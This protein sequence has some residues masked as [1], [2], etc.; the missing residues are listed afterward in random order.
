MVLEASRRLTRAHSGGLCHM[1]GSALLQHLKG[2]H[3]SGTPCPRLPAH[4]YP[5][6]AGGRAEVGTRGLQA[7]SAQAACA[8]GEC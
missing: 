5:H 2:R 8:G 6:Q 1:S 4:N 3:S 7:A